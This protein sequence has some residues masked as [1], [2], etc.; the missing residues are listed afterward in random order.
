MSDSE[1]IK[2]FKELPNSCE[3][4]IRYKRTEPR[5]IVGFSLGT[6]FNESIAMDIKEI[7]DNNVLHLMVKDTVSD[8]LVW[9]GFMAYQLL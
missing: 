5:P 8:G 7:N 1:F 6:H 9:F 4:C 2:F 3:V